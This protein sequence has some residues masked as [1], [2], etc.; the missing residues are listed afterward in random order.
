M[1]CICYVVYIMLTWNEVISKLVVS[2]NYNYTNNFLG[3]K[4]SFF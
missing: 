2:Y 1:I 4:K 3:I